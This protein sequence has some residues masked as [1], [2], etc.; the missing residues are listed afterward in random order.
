MRDFH[1]TEATLREIRDM[2]AGGATDETLG[3]V[4]D[5]LEDIA[6][7]IQAVSDAEA[8]AVGTR[9]GIPV[10]SSDPT[11]HNNAKYYAEQAGA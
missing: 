8:W 4:A 2:L 11:Y 3:A 5:A 6:A 7:Q 1:A 10:D 9:N